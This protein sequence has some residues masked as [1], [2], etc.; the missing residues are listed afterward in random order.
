MHLPPANQQF[1]S[2]ERNS[3]RELNTGPASC[4]TDPSTCEKL[5]IIPFLTSKK[6]YSTTQTLFYGYYT[7]QPALTG[8]SS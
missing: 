5:N 3:Q 4:S 1:Q 7:G 2:T 6:D 8:T